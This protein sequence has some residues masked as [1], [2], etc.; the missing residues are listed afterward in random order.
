MCQLSAGR[1]PVYEVLPSW[2]VLLPIERTVAFDFL[3][4]APVFVVLNHKHLVH[5][6]DGR[7]HRVR[8]AVCVWVFRVIA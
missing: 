4:S 7:R 5:S 6:F 2:K 8:M 3:S 1:S